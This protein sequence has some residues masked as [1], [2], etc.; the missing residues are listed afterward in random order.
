MAKEEI[1]TFRLSG[2]EKEKLDRICLQLGVKRS[3]YI[4]DLGNSQSVD[5][6]CIR[7]ITKSEENRIL[8]RQIVTEINKIGV[9]INQIVHN[10]N[11]QFYSKDE[12]VQLMEYLNQIYLKLN[13]YFG[14]DRT[15]GD[16]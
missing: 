13:D 9:N 14:S 7:Y 4:R 10:V 8:K 6:K 12:K 16:N 3:G 15:N 2:R 11:M 1:V 5:E